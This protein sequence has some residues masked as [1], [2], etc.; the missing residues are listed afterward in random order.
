MKRGTNM[1]NF[2]WLLTLP[3]L[4]CAQEMEHK[5]PEEIQQELD[6]AEA[7][8]ERA[9]KMFNPWYA[10]PLVTPSASMMPPGSANIQPY[11]FIQGNYAAFNEDRK[12]ISL[13]HNLYTATVMTPMQVGVTSSTDVVVNPSAQASWQNHHSGG[14]FG[15][16]GVTYGFKIQSETLY[17][18]KFKFTVGETFPTGRYKNLNSTGLNG[19][20]GGSYKTTFGFATGKLIWWTY[21]NPMNTRLFIGYTISTTVNVSG[22]NA[23][24][25]GI[26]TRGRVRPGNEITADFGY[27][28]SFNQKWVLAL[29]VVYVCQNRTKFHGTPGVTKTGAT[30]AVGGGFNDNLSLAPALEYNFSDVFAVLAGVQ[31]SVYGRNSANFINGQLSVEYSW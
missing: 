2:F 25:G 8:F 7:K 14:G 13:E 18:P 23:Y 19:T 29:D 10:G 4:L 16:L 3:F 30:A 6:D 17:V 5:T 26:G 9:K 12:S 22:Y 24:G 1:R 21:P 11:L 31:F 15:D 27:E 20:G 28:L